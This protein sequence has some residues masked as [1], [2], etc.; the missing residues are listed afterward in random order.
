MWFLVEQT[1]AINRVGWKMVLA[2]VFARP[3]P[4]SYVSELETT[5]WDEAL[6]SVFDRVIIGLDGIIGAKL[7]IRSNTIDTCTLETLPVCQSQNCL[8]KNK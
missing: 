4:G 3:H 7:V 6:A 5:S 1:K 2:A 8:F